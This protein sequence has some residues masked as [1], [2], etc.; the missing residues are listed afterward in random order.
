MSPI[1]N[2]GLIFWSLNNWSTFVKDQSISSSLFSTL[3][4]SIKQEQLY[5][6]LQL[7]FISIIGTES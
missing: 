2:A 1:K 3:S 4:S 6:R 7:I 5:H